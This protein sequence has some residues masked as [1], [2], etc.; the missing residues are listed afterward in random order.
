VIVI[1][2]ILRAHGQ[3]GNPRKNNVQVK[4]MLNFKLFYGILM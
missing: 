3:T 4:L 1:Y 2:Y